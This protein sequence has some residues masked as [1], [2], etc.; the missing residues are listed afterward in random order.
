MQH[1]QLVAQDGQFDILASR[2]GP[3]PATATRRRRTI[4]AIV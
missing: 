3:S 1:G 2:D 4:T